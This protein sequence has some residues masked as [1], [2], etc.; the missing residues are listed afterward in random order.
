M[1]TSEREGIR[2]RTVSW[3]GRRGAQKSR[4]SHRGTHLF[5]RSLPDSAYSGILIDAG[6]GWE[7]GR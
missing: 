2:E 7:R 3:E 6:I 5:R 4:I 1:L